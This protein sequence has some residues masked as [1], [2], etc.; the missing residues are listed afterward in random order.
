MLVCERRGDRE[1]RAASWIFA[2][3]KRG[4]VRHRHALGRDVLDA[5]LGIEKDSRRIGDVDDPDRRSTSV[6]ERS[7]PRPPRR[8]AGTCRRRFAI[9]RG[10]LDRARA[11][12]DPEPKDGQV[13]GEA[14]RLERERHLAVDLGEM[15]EIGRVPERSRRPDLA[16]QLVAVDLQRGPKTSSGTRLADRAA[17]P[18]RPAD[19]RLLCVIRGPV[20]TAAATPAPRAGGRRPAAA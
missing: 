12:D 17:H 19:V 3:G 2:A 18:P 11:V 1:R 16:G 7:A 6:V 13:E 20:P 5:R 4:D 9:P 8:A 15:R 10:M 14:P